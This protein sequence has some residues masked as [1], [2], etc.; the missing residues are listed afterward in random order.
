MWNRWGGKRKLILHF[1][2]EIEESFFFEFKNDECKFRDCKHLKEN[3]CAVL[4]DL[5]NGLILPSRYESYRKMVEDEG[6]NF[7]SKK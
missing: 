7:F 6:S 2:N 4:R 1:L 5:E 3:G